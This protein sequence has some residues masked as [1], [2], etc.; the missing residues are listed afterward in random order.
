MI[1][2]QSTMGLKETLLKRILEAKMNKATAHA[3]SYIQKL[4]QQV[5]ELVGK[6]PDKKK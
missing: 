2:I 6:E 3:Q 5:D 1:N 4:Q